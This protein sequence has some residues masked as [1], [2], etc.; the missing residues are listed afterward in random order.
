MQNHSLFS[1]Q[2]AVLATMHQKEKVIAP[3]LAEVGIN[4]IV[5]P[6]FN[7]DIF[8]TFSRDVERPRDQV[9]TARLKAEKA[10]EV[11]GEKM[12]IASEGSFIPHPGIPYIP[13]NREIVIFLDKGKDL[14][15]IGEE[16]STE[17]NY[18]HVFVQTVEQAYQFAQKVGFPEHGLIVMFDEVPESSTEIFKGIITQEQ[19]IQAVN[20]VLNH[21]PQGKAYI[22]TDMR[23][24]YNP[25]R[26]KNIAK[27]TRDLVKKINSCCPECSTPGFAI[28]Q[29]VKGLPCAICYA[30]TSLIQT[31]IYQCKKCGFSQEKL[32]PQGIEFADPSQCMYC[33]P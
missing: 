12:A 26:M 32:F 5:P 8:G 21:S 25:T 2:V 23:A 24:M 27:A 16:F 6:N 14:E 10:L 1:S 15:I 22:E 7:S 28:T 31:V 29:V 19:L 13:C 9:T 4:V 20:F 3:I 11:T 33:N 30:P 18:S 17:T